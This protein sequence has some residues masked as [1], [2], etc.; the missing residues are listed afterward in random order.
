MAGCGDASDQ[1]E[2]GEVSGLVTIDGKP[3]PGVMVIFRPETGRSAMATADAEGNYELQYLDGVPGCKLGPN[4]V[5][6]AW[7]PDT[8]DA[9]PL[10]EKY[11]GKLGFDVEVKPG[12]NTI[13]L[14]ME[15]K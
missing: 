2:L 14:V 5:T 8:P 6:F 12:S 4:K 9:V 11:S 13:H 7:P 3:L 10:P 15:S 1:P